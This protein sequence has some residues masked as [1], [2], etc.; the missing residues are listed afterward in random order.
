MLFKSIIFFLLGAITNAFVT[1]PTNLFTHRL[2]MNMEQIPLNQLMNEINTNKISQLLI[3]KS[4]KDIISI[5]NDLHTTHVTHINP[6]VLPSI[7]DKTLNNNININFIDTDLTTQLFN[8]LNYLFTNIVVPF[9]LFNVL[10]NIFVRNIRPNIRFSTN[11]KPNINGNNNINMINPFQMPNNNKEF[12]ANKFNIS[13]SSWVG[14]PEV[15]EEC[16]EV[17]SYMANNTL[18]KDIGAELPRGIL[19]EGPPGTGKTLLAKAI[20]SETNSTFFATSGSEFIELF[21]GVGAAKIRQLFDNARASKPSIIFIDEIDTIGRQRG[22]GINMGNDEREQTLNQLLAEMDGF[23]NNENILIIAATNRKD[24]LD[25]ALVRPGRF[26]RTIRVSLPDKTSRRQLLDFYLNKIKVVT[27]INL[28]YLSEITDGYSGAEIK[29]LINEASILAVRNKQ[30]YVTTNDI[31]NAYEKLTVGLV[32]NIDTR[33][34]NVK[35]RVALHELGHAFI[36]MKY[37]KY[38]DLNK[39]SIKS[40]YSGAGGYTLFNEKDEFKDGG[41]YTKDM[42][43]KRLVITMGG[44]AAESV[45]YGD[46][47][48]SVGAIQDLKQANE[49]ARRMIGLF[50]MGDDLKVFYNQNIDTQLNSF[51]NDV[52]SDATK[53]QMDIESNNLVKLAY[54]Q[55]SKIIEENKDKINLMGKELVEKQ[56]LFGSDFK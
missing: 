52:Y 32:R 48:V 3:D 5:E 22:V 2:H 16:Y 36:T 15:F 30:T 46:D 39:I 47:Y 49:L 27:D 50:G 23:G 44:K 14:S 8:D 56:I 40:T 29:N 33:S 35:L 18:Y 38:F 51:N 21:V 20:A 10:R 43:F 6:I 11:N 31:T 26:D 1:K 45:F 25:K 24:I 9:I 54:L 34:D 13:L 28:D 37:S 55:A 12:D 19:L 17:I 53:E 7:L 4:F 42:L 41:L